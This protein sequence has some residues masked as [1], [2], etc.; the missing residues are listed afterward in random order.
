MRLIREIIEKHKF[1][2]DWLDELTLLI[3]EIEN[4]ILNTMLKN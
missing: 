3:L 2:H 4:N 1:E